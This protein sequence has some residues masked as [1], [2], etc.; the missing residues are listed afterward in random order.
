MTIAFRE[1]A[2]SPQESFGPGGMKARRR[3]LVA[4]EHRHAMVAELL[5]DGYE[6]GG[7][8]RAGY[9]SHP[10][11]VAMR[12][13]VEPWPEAPDDQGPFD[14]VRRQLNAYGGKF[15]RIV[16]DYELLDAGQSRVALPAAEEG[17]F[18]SYRMDLDAEAAAWD[19]QS[20]R[21]A[22]QPE[23]EV[24]QSAVPAL[25]IPLAVHRV[26]WHRVVRPPWAAVRAC[27]GC[28]NAAE[29][30]GAAAETVLFDGAEAETEFVGIDGLR[31]P[32]FAWRVS[33]I[34][35]E[36]AIHWGGNVCGWNHAY[37]ALPAES[38]GWDKLVDALG[39]PPY[40]AADFTA[41]FRFDES[42]I[43]P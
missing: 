15:A 30:L 10:G 39:E 37:R 38:P 11:A 18:L 1:F 19:G 23:V 41:L 31:Q 34:F 27:T 40:R 16:V 5:G 7:T 20:L 24:P 13:R 17:T 3:I 33:Y 43:E 21:W 35:R 6:F 29:F 36:K 32:E 42:G 28:V 25:R 9:P 12:V 8:S 2:G 14:D 22:S 4:W 26:T